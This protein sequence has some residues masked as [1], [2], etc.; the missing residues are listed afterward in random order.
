MPRTF[1][2]TLLGVNAALAVAGTAYAAHEN[3]PPAVAAPIVAAF[4]LQISFYLVPGCPEVRRRLEESLAPAQL[5]AFAVAA[6][7]APYLV[8]S[9]PTGVF[10][11]PALLELAAVCLILGFIFVAVPTKAAGFAWQDAAALGTVGVVMMGRLWRGVYRSP[12]AG[13][14]LEVMGQILLIG[15]GAVAYVSLRRLPR[16]GYRLWPSRAELKTGVAQF[17]LFVPIGLV[18]GWGL[19][20]V[21]FHLPE[22]GA[23]MFLLRIAGTFLGMYAVVALFEELFFRGV[24][25]NLLAQSLG[26]PLAAQAIASV[27]YGLCHLPFRGF[28]NWRLAVVTTILGWFC[29]QAYRQR[30]SIVASSITHA[31]AATA[32]RVLLSA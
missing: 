22:A 11:F 13:L 14:R 26:R 6:S 20:V 18:A 32:A 25:Q 29:G 1:L 27:V 19:G 9:V 12:M 28:P 15:L 7:V 16:T 23:P 10:R 31:L 8:Y 4:L 24:L 30:E 17:V 3:I 5:A 2:F 21:R